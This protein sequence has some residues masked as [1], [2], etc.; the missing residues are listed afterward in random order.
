MES[1]DTNLKRSGRINR[2]QSLMGCFLF[3]KNNI[4]LVLGICIAIAI[5]MYGIIGIIGFSAFPDEFG[6]WAPSAAMLGYDWSEITG[7]GPYYSY[8]YSILL[9]PVLFLFHD[10]ITAYR[11]AIVINLLMQC[12][13]FAILYLILKELFPDAKK[14]VLS[15]TAVIAVLYPAWS[16]YT[17]TTMAESLLNF[18]FVLAIFFMLRFLNKPGIITGLILIIL[19]I[20]LYL[21][22][23]RCIGIV[24]AMALTLIIWLFSRNTHR[25]KKS[26]KGW[27]A[28][29]A[30][31][32]LFAMTFVLKDKVISL[33]YHGT[34]E[35]MLTWN[36]YSGLAYRFS[37]IINLQ[38]LKYLLKDICGKVLYL[39]LATYG[40]GYLGICVCVKRTFNAL[41]NIRRRKACGTDYLWIYIFLATFFQFMVALIYLNGAS[42]PDADRLDNFLHGRYIDF[43][44]PILIG[45][46]IMH[47]RRLEKPQF[48]IAATFLIYLA[49]GGVVL[50]TISANSVRMN[51]PHGFTMVGMSYLLQIP[52]E[53]TI[54]FVIKEIAFSSALTLLTFTVIM[55][56]KKKGMEIILSLI[57]VIQVLLG[58]N[59]CDHFIFPYQSYISGDITMGEW[60][61][62]VH[63]KYPEKEIV[64]LY[65][66]GNPYI[67]L[68][69]FANRDIHISALK[70]S[71]G[72]IAEQYLREDII[73]ISR[74]GGAY[75]EEIENYYK[76][77][78]AGGHLCMYFN[79]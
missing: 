25:Q 46:G 17:M 68:V 30:I 31:V 64:H 23:M 53:D 19:S 70:A 50:E 71:D 2:K 10:P 52:L 16:L 43:L 9:V 66:E 44:L 49:F 38:G 33:L 37:K 27:L 28:I 13:S 45:M 4:Y 58:M 41:G 1:L 47:M 3:F 72:V 24:A 32:V 61:G 36:D 7:L 79:P 48:M 73:L 34:S 62:N 20:Y 22:H 14:T 75:E 15:I 78:W 69:Q 63:D 42:A 26:K 51:K 67:E 8:G 54:S 60:L 77:K 59:A 18:G 5:C 76:E 35:D 21:V 65:E 39:G 56:S 40:I 29:P 12:A 6:Y 57:V 55:L 11:M 74:S